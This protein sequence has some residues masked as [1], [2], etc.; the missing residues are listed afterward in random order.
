MSG[1]VTIG[2]SCVFPDAVDGA[3]SALTSTSTTNDADIIMSGAD[4]TLTISPDQT[5]VWG[6]SIVIGDGTQIILGS[7]TRLSQGSLWYPDSDLDSYPSGTTAIFS[8]TAPAG[9]SRRAFA[10]SSLDANDSEYCPDEYN[11]TGNCN[12]CQTGAIV[13]QSA[14]QD[15]FSDCGAQDCTNKVWGWSG[16]SCLAA[17]STS[18]DGMCNGSASCSSFGEAC[19]S[20]SILV[21]CGSDGCKLGCTQGESITSYDSLGEVCHIDG[22]QH[23]CSSSAYGCNETALCSQKRVFVTNTTYTGNIG[24]LSGADSNC[25]SQ[26]DAASLGGTWKAWLSDASTNASSRLSQSIV[27]YVKVDGTTVV[28]NNW[29]DLTDGSLN[30]AINKDQYGNTQSGLDV[31]TNT[32]TSG[33]RIASVTSYTCTNWSSSSNRVRSY[34][35]DSGY[36][37]IQWTNQGYNTCNKT[38]RLYCFEQ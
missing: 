2:G 10:E 37:N 12:T 16:T 34:Y 25:Q 11:P 19:Q 20:G 32:D 27:P 23:S 15:M 29:S 13:I 5:I 6:G 28:V 36:T 9:Y 24:G 38:F 14:G 7:N 31:W 35:G 26:A 21:T 4:T 1:D 22:S 8:K 30:S 18:L 3:D 17:S 33:N